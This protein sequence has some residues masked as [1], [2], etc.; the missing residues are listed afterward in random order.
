MACEVSLCALR[1]TSSTPADQN[2][3]GEARVGVL[4]LDEGELDSTLAEVLNQFGEL[5]IWRMISMLADECKAQGIIN[6]SRTACALNFEYAL[7]GTA[8][9]EGVDQGSLDREE[10]PLGVGGRA[11]C[12]RFSANDSIVAALYGGAV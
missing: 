5:A 11:G 6:G 10:R 3:L 2:K 8:V 1:D 4:D 7:L 12:R 9:L